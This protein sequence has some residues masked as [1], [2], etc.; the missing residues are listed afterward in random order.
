MNRFALR[1]CQPHCGGCLLLVEVTT[2]P[3]RMGCQIEAVSTCSTF[4]WGFE[5]VCHPFSL[6]LFKFHSLCVVKSLKQNPGRAL[7]E[8]LQIIMASSVPPQCIVGTSPIQAPGSGLGYEYAF[9]ENKQGW[10]TFWPQTSH[11]VWA[12]FQHNWNA[13][14]ML[15]TPWVNA[16]KQISFQMCLIW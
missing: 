12:H 1:A 4:E 16:A 2:K 14:S 9:C 10:I 7:S 13:L 11:C 5:D 8:P 3:V 6:I 15:F